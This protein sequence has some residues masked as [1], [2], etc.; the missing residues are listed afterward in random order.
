MIGLNRNKHKAT[1]I[2]KAKS[3]R[4]NKNCYD[5]V[6][7]RIKINKV[8]KTRRHMLIKLCIDV[9]VVNEINVH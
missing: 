4:V 9:A 7:E 8:A 3:T 6:K 5:C 2:H 1:H